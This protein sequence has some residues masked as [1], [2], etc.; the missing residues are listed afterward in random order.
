[1]DIR[2]QK[3]F[4]IKAY[5]K[6][7]YQEKLLRRPIS[8]YKDKIIEISRKL[9]PTEEDVKKELKLR[10]DLRKYERSISKYYENLIEIKEN[11]IGRI[12]KIKTE[13]KA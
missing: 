2:W 13:L 6:C 1:M 4:L 9:E 8:Y 10:G 12:I 5:H 3:E 7:L 11:I